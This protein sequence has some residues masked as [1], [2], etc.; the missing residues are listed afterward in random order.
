MS[1]VA[2]TA[3]D[4]N[5]P[6]SGRRRFTVDALFTDHRPQAVGVADLP[7]AKEIQLDRIEPDPDQPRHTIDDEKLAELA[8]S[9]L[10]EGV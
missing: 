6:S 3:A 10:I 7:T 8:A 5:K 9:I 4:G 2:A 1:S